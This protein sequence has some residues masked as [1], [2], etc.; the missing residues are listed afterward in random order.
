VK[1]TLV[2]TGVTAAFLGLVAW[3]AANT[4]WAD[5]EVPTPLKGEALVNPFYAVQRLADNL[6]GRTA[7]YSRFALPPT[8]AVVL[9]SAWDWGV[10]TSRRKAIE[11]WVEAGGRLVVDSTLIGGQAAFDRWSGITRG[12]IQLDADAVK[13][14]WQSGN[15]NPCRRFDEIGHGSVEREPGARRPWLC[16]VAIVTFLKT[17]RPIDWGLRDERGAQALRVGIGRGS[18]TVINAAPF[19]H[20]NLFDG[21]HG[22]VF[23]NAA[24]FKRGDEVFFLTED[25][26]PSLVALMWRYGAPVVMLGLGAVA[27]MLWR[28]AVR[29]GPLAAPPASSRRSL[30]EQIRGTGKFLVRNGGADSLH[31]ATVRALDEAATRRVRGYA[32]QTSQER[33]ATLSQL[34]GFDAGALTDAVHHPRMRRPYELRRTIALLEA[35]RRLIL[36]ERRRTSHGRD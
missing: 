22:V 23:V 11:D 6:G 9:L 20:R 31:A 17:D 7:W 16:D 27:L 10:N 1:R 13:D 12:V 32:R 19:Q 14:Q 36:T 28:G 35:A 21:D 33:A 34:T 8:N 2:W 3:V 5:T 24:Q 15:Y 4:H 25:S 18:V 30:A 29:F 26:H